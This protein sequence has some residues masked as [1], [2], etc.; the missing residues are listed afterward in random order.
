[1]SSVTSTGLGSGLDIN[2]IVG[3]IVGAEKDPALSK[4]TKEDAK[5][6]AIISAYG[7]LNGDLDDFKS[8]YKDL[9]Y[10]STF[11]AAS[12]SSSDTSILDTKLGVGAQTGTW[13]FEIKQKA[14][15]QTLVSG[16]N[17]SFS[18][19][20]D[21]IGEGVISLRFGAYNEDGS[22]FSVNADRPI[23]KITID[24][25]NNS[26]EG[27]RN[28]IN[29]GDY[30]VNASIINDGNNYRLVLTSKTTGKENA[31]EITVADANGDALPSSNALNNFTYTATQKNLEQTSLAQ[32]AIIV[33][34]GIQITRDSNEITSVIEGVTL[35]ING[36]TAPGKKVT[37]KID[38]DNSKV[39]EQIEAFVENYNATFAKMNELTSYKGAKADNNGVL[40]GD[41]TIRNIKSMM[42]GVLNTQVKHIQGSIHSFA[43]LGI[44]TKR[45]GTLELNSSKFEDA[46]K[47]DMQGIAD[48]FTAT[49]VASDTLV[50]FDKNSSLTKPGTYDVEILKL[51][52]QATLKD[53]LV[54]SL[55]PSV[56]SGNDTFKMRIDGYLSEDIV[57]SQKTYASI[58]DLATEMQLKINSDPNFI[59]N[60]ISISVLNDA[61]KLS[62][63]SNKY[64][65]GSS[66]AFNEVGADFYA[67]FGVG[68]VSAG[69]TGSNVHGKIDGHL[70]Y[71]DGQFLLSE[72]GDST[73]IKL[74]IE[75]GAL[76]P[77]GDVTYAEGMTKLMN[78]L[79]SGIIDSNISGSSGDTSTSSGIIDGKVDSL[80]K[81]IALLDTRKESLI[82]RMDKLEA[83]LYKN[84]NAMDSAVSMMGNTMTNLK[85]SLKALPGYTRD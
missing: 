51:A 65:S 55:T 7:L 58:D 35:N 26:L 60:G 61:G 10:S 71:G 82:Y 59:K 20:K 14:Q 6:T 40:N 43:D 70:G 84:F 56:N 85:N 77:R 83:R 32:D 73:G 63:T 31:L 42:R 49:G 44:L 75:G 64:G 27:L 38:A 41:S 79:L 50:S 53:G 22:D 68:V 45:D 46:L 29:N 72:K 28:T 19:V 15:A 16:A 9:A 74:L 30:S 37:L 25:K 3:A 76:G 12:A 39:K 81:K 13:Q 47:N 67:D 1:M 66:L 54:S 11:S 62:F 80:Y 2:A 23:E 21:P 34:N 52:T 57:L 17:S 69:I 24:G 48:F 36:E 33:M 78:N 8:S 5:A 4:I 18:S